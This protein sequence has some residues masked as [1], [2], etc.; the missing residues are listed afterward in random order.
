M[1]RESQMQLILGCGCQAD[2]SSHI[3]LSTAVAVDLYHDFT[4]RG[5]ALALDITQRNGRGLH[6]G[7]ILPLKP[8]GAGVGNFPDG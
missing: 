8:A 2:G 1:G 5:G 3:E 4:G 6:E 7:G